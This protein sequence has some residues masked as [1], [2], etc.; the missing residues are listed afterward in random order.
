MNNSLQEMIFNMHNLHLLCI[1]NLHNNM[2]IYALIRD[3]IGFEIENNDGFN[4]IL[5]EIQIIYIKTKKLIIEHGITLIKDSQIYKNIYQR[6]LIILYPSISNIKIINFRSSNG[7]TPLHLACKLGDILLV[8]TMIENGADIFIK[9]KNNEDALIIAALNGNIEIVKLLIEKFNIH[10]IDYQLKNMLD[11]KDDTDEINNFIEQDILINLLFNN[12][13][14]IADILIKNNLLTIIHNGKYIDQILYFSIIY[15]RNDKL[16]EYLDLVIKFDIDIDEGKEYNRVYQKINLSKSP[17]IKLNYIIHVYAPLISIACSM[18]NLYAVE[19]LIKFNNIYID[20][21]SLSNDNINLTPIMISYFYNNLE[22]IEL[23]LNHE[24]DMTYCGSY[25]YS[26]SNKFHI[27]YGTILFMTIERFDFDMFKKFLNYCSE[28]LEIA[29][30][31]GYTI[32]DKA[33]ETN[34]LM[35]IKYLINTCGFNVNH[36]DEEVYSEGGEYPIFTAVNRGHLETV[37]LLIENGADVNLKIK[38]QRNILISAIHSKNILLIKYLTENFK[39]LLEEKDKYGDNALLVAAEYGYFN[40]VKF[41]IENDADPYCEDNNK[42]NILDKAIY[43]KNIELIN[44][45]NEN[46]TF[47]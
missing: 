13:F 19:Y 39:F 44:F 17:E 2:D 43:S 37:K 5:A 8:N 33:S 41:L 4:V 45:L 30:G 21:V 9:D 11:N 32:L 26:Q 31:S 36:I 20:I 23:L 15:E 16:Q 24:C 38:N 7:T 47:N 12:Y 3:F 28:L 14:E 6:L 40:I 42:K 46:F 29:N 18:N 25:E 27:F 35:V 10:D 22:C 1:E 34:N